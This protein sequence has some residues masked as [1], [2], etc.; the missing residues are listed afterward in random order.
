MPSEASADRRRRY[1]RAKAATASATSAGTRAAISAGR[2]SSGRPDEASV[3]AARLTAAS[4]QAS[5]EPLQLRAHLPGQAIAELREVLAHLVE[6]GAQ[7]VAIDLQQPLEIAARDVEA[8]GI[9][10]RGGRHEPDRRRRR[11]GG[12]LAAAHDPR[13]H[14]RVLA[15]ARP[16]ELAV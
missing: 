14:A 2:R 1:A 10:R 4:C 7:A 3:S 9:E 11:V 6:L 16:Q 5:L 13:Q 8:F 15:E 12:V